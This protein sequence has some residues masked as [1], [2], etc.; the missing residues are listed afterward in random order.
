AGKFSMVQ[1]H[2]PGLVMYNAQP[3]PAHKGFSSVYHDPKTGLP[4]PPVYA[5]YPAPGQFPH[6]LYSPEFTSASWHRSH[7]PITSG[8]FAGSF[9]PSLTSLSCYGPSG[10]LPHLG[11]PGIPHPASL[12]PGPKSELMSPQLLQETHRQLN[13][14]HRDENSSCKPSHHSPGAG[15]DTRKRPYVKK[16]LNAFMLFMK[17][18]RPKVISECTLKES[19]AINQILGRR[20][21]ALD[22]SEQAKYYDMAR[23]EKE[24]HLQRYP[25]WSARDNYAA[26][27]KKK[28]RKK[29]G[30]CPNDRK[31]RA[32]Y[33]VD[34]Q[35]RWCK[36]C[37]SLHERSDQPVVET[38]QNHF[39]LVKA[40]EEVHPL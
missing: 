6:P 8:A 10:I 3:P 39:V 14:L 23:K 28:K 33:G 5:A 1:P 38:D 4:R 40:K 27:Q 25:G 24:V 30:E 9:P 15:E 35:S 12:G 11:H 22:R 21:H 29:D 34:Q 18:M 32:R 26:H 37:R 16:P 20:W 19:A 31:C 36:P 7:Y 17:E 13:S 2:Y